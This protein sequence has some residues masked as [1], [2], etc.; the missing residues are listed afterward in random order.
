MKNYIKKKIEINKIKNACNLAAKVLEMIEEHIIDGVTTNHINN[1][2]HKYITNELKAY[3]ASLNYN[4]FP[5]SVCISV[6]EEVCHGI[7]NE[8]I[9]KNGDIINIDVTIMKNGYYGDT[10]KMFTIGNISNE[11]KNLIKIT[12]ECLYNAVKKIKHN[13]NLSIIGKTIE[14]HAEKYNYKIIKEYC[15]HGIGKNLHEDPYILHYKNDKNKIKIYTGMIFTI[16]PILTTGDGKTIL[17]KDGWT[18]LTQ[19]KSLSA[20]WEHTILVTEN[21][22]EI[23]TLRKNEFFY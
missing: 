9:L 3:P 2:C 22:Y 15:G 23:L 21:S 1:I 19:D 6:N 20:Q 14:S 12:Q 17:S 18:V 7:P 11:A 4:G 8:K 10:S 16:E 13:E 5:K